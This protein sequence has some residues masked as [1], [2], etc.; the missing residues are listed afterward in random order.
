MMVSLFRNDLKQLKNMIVIYCGC[1]LLNFLISM[2]SFRQDVTVITFYLIVLG[3]TLLAPLFNL[4]YLFNQTKQT[5]YYSL[6]F[7]KMQSFIIHYL[8]GISCLIVPAA[9]YC[10]LDGIFLQGLVLN[11]SLALLVM[12]L[13]YYS[14]SS[15]ATYLTTSVVMEIVLQVLMMIIPPILYLSLYTIYGTFV[16]GIVMDGL[17]SEMLSYLMPFA[18]L[19]ISGLKGLTLAD[20]LLYLGYCVIIFALAL[21]A[22][23]KRS[24][25][26]NCYG[27]AYKYAPSLLKLLVIICASWMLTAILG[28]DYASIRTFVI[29]NII[30]TVV[31]TFIIQ[32][33]QFR[34][35]KYKLCIVEAFILILTTT[36]V[37]YSS[38][39]Y[40]ENYIPDQIVA[41]SI[42][43]DEN[44]SS[45]IKITNEESIKKVVAIHQRL[46]KLK[47]PEENTRRIKITYTK[48]N[49]SQVAR[50]YFVDT[51]L[52]K[53]L[54]SQFN[55]DI[56]KSY[57]GKYY[58][59]LKEIDKAQ[60]IEYLYNESNYTL[61][62]K[63]NKNLFKDILKNKLIAFENDSSLLQEISYSYDCQNDLHVYFDSNF[64]SNWYQY[65]K[66]DPLYLTIEEFAKIKAN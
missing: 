32:F 44:N 50:Y 34:K 46:I 14:L 61:I 28:T 37:F 35:I 13:M 27:F 29:T 7:T 15:L 64:N 59:L 53:D 45:G 5:H 33:I 12:I 40:L 48:P 10:L 65:G 26:V 18:N 51:S 60:K 66:N 47:T 19:I 22:C 39:E 58:Q 1:L 57:N 30:A 9:L 2:L 56:I 63:A 42:E 21:F 49:Q 25:S 11:N 3:F 36:S 38:R 31:V 8:S 16:K 43:P 54:A 62:S 55:Q 23:K 20:S 52:F 24:C 41:V 17:S 6:P 4:N